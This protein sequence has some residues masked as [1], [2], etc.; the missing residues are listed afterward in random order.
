M[1]PIKSIWTHTDYVKHW[2]AEMNVFLSFSEHFYAKTC[3][4]QC[5]VHYQ[6]PINDK[7]TKITT[8]KITNKKQKN[9]LFCCFFFLCL[10]LTLCLLFSC[11]FFQLVLILFISLTDRVREFEYFVC[12]TLIKMFHRFLPFFSFVLSSLFFARSSF[13]FKFF[14]S[15]SVQLLNVCRWMDFLNRLSAIL[16]FW[17][18]LTT[19]SANSNSNDSKLQSIDAI[20]HLNLFCEPFKYWNVSTST[21]INRNEGEIR[22]IDFEKTNSWNKI[23]QKL[24]NNKQPPIKLLVGW[25]RRACYCSPCDYWQATNTMTRKSAHTLTFIHTQTTY[26][27]QCS[28]KWRYI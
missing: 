1:K 14:P 16:C 27:T 20:L 12:A 24:K 26:W 9:Q 28:T 13:K 4:L 22:K 23:K 3:S 25:L 2:T 19:I 17:Q 7:T 6:L 10:C 5:C 21:Y 18:I 8:T 11:F 15:S